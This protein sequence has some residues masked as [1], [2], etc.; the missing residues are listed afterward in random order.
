MPFVCTIF[1]CCGLLLQN[2]LFWLV[3]VWLLCAI[4]A[5]WVIAA[6]RTLYISSSGHRQGN[7]LPEHCNL[8]ATL[9]CRPLVIPL[10][11]S[12]SPSAPVAACTP[13][14]AHPS[15]ARISLALR[16]V[17]PPPPPPPHSTPATASTPCCAP[18][19]A[20][21][22]H[23]VPAP[24]PRQG[25]SFHNRNLKYNL[26]VAPRWPQQSTLRRVRLLPPTP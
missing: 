26:P 13:H 20:Y 24:P 16:A 10:S 8:V 19:T 4:A 15:S 9:F 3:L 6:P 23:S 18:A 17:P 25:H 11:D 14:I 2:S 21:T 22:T 1:F 5:P 7:I 12:T